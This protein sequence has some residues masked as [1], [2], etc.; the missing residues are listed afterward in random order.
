MFPLI[1]TT[2]TVAP[3]TGSVADLLSLLQQARLF[4]GSD[5]GPAHLASLTGAPMVLLFGPTDPLE[6][7]PFPG[8]RSR[9]LRRDVGCNPCRKGCPARSCMEA[10]GVDEVVGAALELVAGPDGL[11]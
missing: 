9:V 11:E 6:N 7:A 4:I 1:E 5:S 3:A 2:W 10:L 8:S